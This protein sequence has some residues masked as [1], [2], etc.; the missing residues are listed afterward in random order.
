MS[1]SKSTKTTA[2]GAAAMATT[3]SRV[4]ELSQHV[5]RVI[6]NYVLVWFDANFDE[7]DE[8]FKKSLQHLRKTVASIATFTNV[9]EGIV[10]LNA[11]KKEKIFM[12]VSG[13]LGQQIVPEIEAW[14]RLESIY[15]FCGNREVHEQWARKIQ[16]VKGVHTSIEP[17]CDALQVDRENCDRAMIPICFNGI[18]TLFMYTQLLKEIFLDIEDDDT[19]LIKELAEYCRLQNDIDEDEIAKVEQEY[20]DHTP[21]WWYTAP[22]FMNSVLNCG[23]RLMDVDIVLRLGFFIR[24]LHQ[25]IDNL[26]QEQQ[27]NKKITTTFTVFR[28]QGLSVEVFEKMKKTEDGLMS[29]NNFLLTSENRQV[30]LQLAREGAATNSNMVGILFIMTIDPT[31]SSNS[32]IP[33]VDISREGFYEINDTEILF[34]TH[35]IFRIDH[36][37]PIPDDHTDRLWQVNLTLVGNDNPE[38]DKITSSLREE[39]SC[40]T[41]WSRLGHILIQLGEPTKA[42]Q[43]YKILLEKTSSNEEISDYNQQLGRI[44]RR[45]LQNCT[46]QKFF[47]PFVSDKKLKKLLV[48]P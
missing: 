38:L 18:D 5:R 17:I 21:I 43:L 42:E 8:D 33:Y 14:P 31:I 47:K 13:S 2:S 24:D 22:F 29:F 25:Y 39:F 16:K 30:S 41:G 44:A 34:T 40:S 28:G 48:K 23:L 4:G 1:K 36:I 26:Y 27:S 11:I 19:K 3:T 20:H 46:Y 10:F 7:S 37:Q 15:V 6:Q 35:T 32:S 9:Q 12:I 45:A